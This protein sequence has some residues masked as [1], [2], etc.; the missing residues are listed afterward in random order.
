MSSLS[1][2]LWREVGPRCPERVRCRSDLL[3]P[4]VF[5]GKPS[6]VVVARVRPSIRVSHSVLTSSREL[7]S[8]LLNFGC[9]WVEQSL[10]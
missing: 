10:P 8:R 2:P 5:D 7:T 6:V 3:D 9:K 4:G 1:S